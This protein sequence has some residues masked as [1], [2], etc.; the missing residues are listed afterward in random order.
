VGKVLKRASRAMD[1]HFT[2]FIAR[3]AEMREAHAKGAPLLR[4]SPRSAVK[5]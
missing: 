3:L 5:R 4:K 1:V 2:R